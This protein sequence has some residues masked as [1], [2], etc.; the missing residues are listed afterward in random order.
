M[1]SILIEVFFFSLFFFIMYSLIKVQETVWSASY[2]R[3]KTYKQSNDPLHPL[4]GKIKP[5]KPRAHP[6][7]SQHLRRRQ[8][9][10]LPSS[11]HLRKDK[12]RNQTRERHKP[13]GGPPKTK[14]EI[15]TAQV[16]TKRKAKTTIAGCLNGISPTKRLRGNAFTRAECPEIG[17]ASDFRRGQGGSAIP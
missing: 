15:Y 16:P 13:F 6:S 7:P 2:D 8:D 5:L 14:E 12:Y 11:R 9:G 4:I 3:N 1:W 17:D 10:A